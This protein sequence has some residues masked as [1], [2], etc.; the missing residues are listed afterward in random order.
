MLL[1]NKVYNHNSYQIEIFFCEV[2]E[3]YVIQYLMIR[4]LILKQN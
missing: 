3:T 4:N 2:Y 1:T